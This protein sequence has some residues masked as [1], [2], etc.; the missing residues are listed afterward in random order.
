[1][2]L[3]SS[4]P[5]L[6]FKAPPIECNRDHKALNRGTLW[7]LGR[8]L[9]RLRFLARTCGLFASAGR[10]RIC[11]RYLPQSAQD[12]M[13]LE[14]GISTEIVRVSQSSL[15][16]WRCPHPHAGEGVLGPGLF[17]FQCETGELTLP[18]ITQHASSG[19]AHDSRH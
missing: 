12:D 3:A 19:D 8:T 2:E 4:T 13:I 18:S 17:Q 14:Y 15:G 16:I 10:L 1:M 11:S 9:D 5:Q 7:A 6:P